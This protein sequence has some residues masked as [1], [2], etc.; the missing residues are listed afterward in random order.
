[1]VEVIKGHLP[2]VRV[3]VDEALSVGKG[4]WKEALAVP[5]LHTHSPPSPVH[6]GRGGPHLMLPQPR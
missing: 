3:Q 6:S 5:H 4:E 2:G 1:M